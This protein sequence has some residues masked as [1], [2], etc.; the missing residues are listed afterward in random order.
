LLRIPR[1]PAG[2][3]IDK[4]GSLDPFNSKIWNRKF[5]VK[6]IDSKPRSAIGEESLLRI[7]DIG[8]L[9]ITAFE[10]DT[11]AEIFNAP[12]DDLEVIGIDTNILL[13]VKTFNF[14]AQFERS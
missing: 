5:S 10:Y 13:L 7:M 4:S 1:W 8:E 2:V 11:D 3:I 9:L 14:T 6:V 12:D